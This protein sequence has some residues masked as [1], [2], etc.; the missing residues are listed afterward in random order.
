MNIDELNRLADWYNDEYMQLN[1]LYNNLLSPIQQNATQTSKVPVENQLENLLSFLR[2][3][4]FEELSLRQLQML[5]DFGV[6]SF[7]GR[8]GAQYVEGSI[9]TAE[10]DPA[11][12]VERITAAMSKLGELHTGLNQYHN[13]LTALGLDDHDGQETVDSIVIRVGFQNGAA[14]NNVT[15][16]KES[17]K[18]WYE[19]IRGL[20]LA[21]GE[22]PEETKIIGASSG[23]IILI[24]AG[25]IQVTTLLA[26]V[27]K[28]VASVA[29]EIIGIQNQIE[30]LRHKKWLNATIENEFKKQEEA[31]KG[32]SLT[33]IIALIRG[34][35]PNL[36]GEQVTA[37]EGSIKKLLTFNEKGGN[38]DFVAPEAQATTE[39]SEEEGSDENLDPL[40]E[41]QAVIREYQA[42]RE[43]LKLLTDGTGGA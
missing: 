35:L 25:T 6:D 21:A 16:W 4:S 7:I 2:S 3:M 38:V 5:S 20:A 13:A 42:T 34:R 31:L 26:L 37:L 12:A 39:E 9:R 23:S 19:I 1:K 36:D 15:E 17:A 28:V 14:I 10:Y 33:D 40:A 41:V 11:T 30:D 27:S 22:A 24:F 29:K 43:Q 32:K 18:D 8:D